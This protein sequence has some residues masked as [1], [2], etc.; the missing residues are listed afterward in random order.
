MSEDDRSA[1]TAAQNAQ[2]QATTTAGNLGQ[3]AAGIGSQIIPGL[4][5][6]TTTPPGFSPVDLARME[7]TAQ[8]AAGGTA[9]GIK[10]DLAL[11]AMRNRNPAG[12]NAA[13]A[14]VAQGA[15]RAQGNV[16]QDALNQNANLKEKQRMQAYE[17]LGGIYG[18]D[19][20]GM[21][22][23]M[24]LVPEDINA[25]VNAGKSGWYQN[26]LAGIDTAAGAGSGAAGA[27][28]NLALSG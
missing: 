22:K 15:S 4:E 16:L 1:Q 14:S 12:L 24:S 10:G 18:T 2:Q 27:Y 13:S 3:T 7:T 8:E 5:R 6:M 20:S 9:S 25:E 23:A 28:K 19:T 11:R 17:Q 21:L 26:L